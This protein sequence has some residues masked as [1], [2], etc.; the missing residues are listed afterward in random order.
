MDIF[1]KLLTAFRGAAADAGLA[2]VEG[3]GRGKTGKT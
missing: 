2:A 1:S 3:L